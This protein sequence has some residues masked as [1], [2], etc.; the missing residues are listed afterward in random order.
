MITKPAQAPRRLE[1]VGDW[2]QDAEC[3]GQPTEWFFP[4]KGGNGL[5][6]RAKR[7]CAV[8]IAREPCLAYAMRQGPYLLGVWGGT[9]QN[10]RKRLRRRQRESGGPGDGTTARDRARE[11]GGRSVA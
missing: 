9:T 6:K 3:L 11:L 2:A 1:L 8:C 7:I 5:I 4:E 10:D